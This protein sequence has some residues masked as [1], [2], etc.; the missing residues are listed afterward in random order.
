MTTNK[1]AV[2]QTLFTTMATSVYHLPFFTY[3]C[4]YAGVHSC[5]YACINY[6]TLTTVMIDGYF[7]DVDSIFATFLI[8]MCCTLT[9]VTRYGSRRRNYGE[10]KKHVLDFDVLQR[11][12]TTFANISAPARFGIFVCLGFG[13]GYIYRYCLHNRQ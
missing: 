5:M 10:Q 11:Y 12:K 13:N 3:L 1:F 7:C 2:G 4:M 6:L 9:H 8:S